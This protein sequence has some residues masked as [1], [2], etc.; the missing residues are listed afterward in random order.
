MC[1]TCEAHSLTIG[2]LRN[3]LDR[4][5]ERANRLEQLL[6][7]YTGINPTSS[8]AADDAKPIPGKLHWSDVAK[9][10]EKQDREL[11]HALTNKVPEGQDV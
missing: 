5:T 1:R 7:N 6:L 4:E 3:Q 8:S 11:L 10:L 2:L 9:K